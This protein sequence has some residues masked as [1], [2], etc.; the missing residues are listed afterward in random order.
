MRFQEKRKGQYRGPE[1]RKSCIKR[2]RQERGDSMEW[3]GYK[4]SREV[5]LGLKKK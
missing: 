1:E 4:R 2:S 5:G 3:I